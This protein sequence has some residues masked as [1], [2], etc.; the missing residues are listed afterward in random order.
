MGLFKPKWEQ[1]KMGSVDTGDQC[2]DYEW[3][4]VGFFPCDQ[5]QIY[6]SDLD[7]TDKT[8]FTERK[9]LRIAG[10]PTVFHNVCN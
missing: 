9:M 5:Q 3:V 1:E 6:F 10:I 2:L 4:A 7:G 8:P